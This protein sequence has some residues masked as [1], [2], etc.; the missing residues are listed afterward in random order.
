MIG[1]DHHCFVTEI[2]VLNFS[3]LEIVIFPISGRALVNSDYT[4]VAESYRLSIFSGLPNKQRQNFTTKKF[5]V[6]CIKVKHFAS[7]KR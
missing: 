2:E 3:C 4:T 5:Y 1:G 6:L 7:G